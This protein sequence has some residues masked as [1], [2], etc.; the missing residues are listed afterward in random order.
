[1]LEPR[2]FFLG[3]YRV[4]MWEYK[5]G[6]TAAQIELM[7][8]DKPLTMYGKKDKFSA[9]SYEELEECKIRYEQEHKDDGG[10]VDP[11]KLMQN[12]K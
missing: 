6:M 7:S 10:I 3:L 2:Y 11:K 9:P 1:M 5:C 8:V 4:P 12:F